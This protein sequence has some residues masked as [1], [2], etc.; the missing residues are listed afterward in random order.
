[1]NSRVL[2]TTDEDEVP[3]CF[4]TLWEATNPD[5]NRCVVFS[6]CRQKM[7]GA[8]VEVPS[9]P[10]EEVGPLEGPVLPQVLNNLG[11]TRPF[12]VDAAMPPDA[13]LSIPEPSGPEDT[14]WT[15]LGR[16]LLRGMG[17]SVGWTI[18]NFFDQIPL[19]GLFGRKK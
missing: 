14:P 10:T 17:K 1:M 7:Q 19:K 12:R 6:S 5:C 2:P 16:A 9:G 11:T 8:K 15:V 13:L 4:G 3:P 18:A